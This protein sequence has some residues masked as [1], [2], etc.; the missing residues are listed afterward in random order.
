MLTPLYNRSNR[1]YQK[2]LI[3]EENIHFLLPVVEDKCGNVGKAE[4]KAE[5]WQSSSICHVWTN[6]P[7]ETAV[8]DC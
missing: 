3:I 2:Q 4:E 8:R 5:E 6:V 1:F 7:R